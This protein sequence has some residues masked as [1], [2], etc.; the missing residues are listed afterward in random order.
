MST[1]TLASERARGA[2]FLVLMGA[3]L[4]VMGLYFAATG[5]AQI[6]AGH[7][8]RDGGRDGGLVS[9]M[10]AGWLLVLCVWAIRRGRRVQR[11]LARRNRDLEEK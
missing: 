8:L 10:L 2:W 3:V 11:E 4:L 9:V 1:P 5:I 6:A 7:W